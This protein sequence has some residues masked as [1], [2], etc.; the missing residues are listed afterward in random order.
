MPLS[1]ELV[2]ALA[3]SRRRSR[4]SNRCVDLENG[5]R[6]LLLQEHNDTVPADH[7]DDSINPNDSGPRL[8]VTLKELPN[9]ET[10]ALRAVQAELISG[11]CPNTGD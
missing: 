8:S 3:R 11:C 2:E 7:P 4:L 5:V 1:T 9:G 6:A 10:Y